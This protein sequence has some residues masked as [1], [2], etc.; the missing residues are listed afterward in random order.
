MDKMLLLIEILLLGLED[1]DQGKV[2]VSQVVQ[3]KVL[4]PKEFSI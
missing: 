3:A 4:K 2:L 1:L